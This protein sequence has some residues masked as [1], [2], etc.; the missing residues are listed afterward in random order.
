MLSTELGACQQQIKSRPVFS[1][2][3]NTVTYTPSNNKATLKQ[4]H[5][6][7]TQ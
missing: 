3:V 4:L 2:N 1:A 7:A 5:R 6:E